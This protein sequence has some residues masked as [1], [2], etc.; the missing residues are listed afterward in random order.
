LGEK[1]PDQLLRK[2]SAK[3]WAEWKSYY[4]VEPFGHDLLFTLISYL[5]S[6]LSNVHS[7]KGAKKLRPMDFY[8]K[9]SLATQKQSS[10]E[11]KEAMMALVAET[12]PKAKKP[13]K[14]S[15]R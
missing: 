2:L 13:K 7:K 9:V 8:Q 10:D 4:N 11:I 3:Q 12:V 5:C 15:K 6:L 1:H 14:D